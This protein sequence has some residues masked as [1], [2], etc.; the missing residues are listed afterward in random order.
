MGGRPSLSCRDLIVHLCREH[1]CDERKKE[2]PA[3]DEGE[4]ARLCGGLWT[5]SLEHMLSG[6]WGHVNSFDEIFSKIFSRYWLGRSR[7]S[8]PYGRRPEAPG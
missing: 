3:I 7:E 4:E 8:Q 6:G 5:K 2:A 1:A